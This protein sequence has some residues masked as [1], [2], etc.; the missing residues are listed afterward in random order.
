MS[1]N[2]L[3]KDLSENKI[4][5]KVHRKISNKL[6][7]SILPIAGISIIN[8]VFKYLT[9]ICIILLLVDGIYSLTKVLLYYKNIS[10]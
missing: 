9:M 4:L 2:K 3:A 1:F 7:C 6:L 10:L 8:K 5:S